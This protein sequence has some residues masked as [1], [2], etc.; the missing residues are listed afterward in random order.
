MAATSAPES[1]E[2]TTKS[3]NWFRML[4]IA[5]VI[6]VIFISFANRN[7]E[8]SETA[9][10]TET[11]DP[12]VFTEEF[13]GGLSAGWEWENEVPG[14]WSVDGGFLHLNP[15]PVGP[16]DQSPAQNVLLRPPGVEA[17]SVIT[18][19]EF[20]PSANFHAAGITIYQDE[21]NMIQLVHGFCTSN[22]EPCVDEGVYFD[23]MVDG[24][25]PE[26][27]GVSALTQSPD[28][29]FLRINANA[30]VYAGWYSIDGETWASTGVITAQLTSP[31]VGIVA[32]GNDPQ[33]PESSFDFFVILP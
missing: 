9:D 29:L 3:T 20:S 28:R 7:E 10:P 18:S 13:G 27:H 12:T 5:V 15:P 11:T 24:G 14:R 16:A 21:E 19:I 8:S 22:F 33:P 23:R 31:R 2:K 30:N 25:I 26:S 1:V 32:E 4:W 17:Y 6:G